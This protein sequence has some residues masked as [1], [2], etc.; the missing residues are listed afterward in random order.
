MTVCT[1]RRSADHA[2]LW[3][4]TITLAVGRSEGYLTL[5]HLQLKDEERLLPIKNMFL[6]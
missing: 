2:S 1:V 3:K 5:K 4:I 6:E